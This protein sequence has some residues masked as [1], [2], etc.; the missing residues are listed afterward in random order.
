MGHLADTV[1]Y[2]VASVAAIFHELERGSNK[3][4]EGVF[5]ASGLSDVVRC[6]SL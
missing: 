4:A 5:A 6:S 1:M 2:R 3:F